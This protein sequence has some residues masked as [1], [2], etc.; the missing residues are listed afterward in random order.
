MRLFWGYLAGLGLYLQALINITK[1]GAIMQTLISIDCE[2]SDELIAHLSKIVSQIVEDREHQ[3]GEIRSLTN[4]NDDN[5]Y[6]SHSVFINP[7]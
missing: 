1:N 2:T 6:G 7:N 3:G 5:C 4:L